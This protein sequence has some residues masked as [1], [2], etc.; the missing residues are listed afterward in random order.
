MVSDD[1]NGKQ[2]PYL[3]FKNISLATLIINGMNNFKP[4]LSIDIFR[5]SYKI[6]IWWIP[7]DPT[8]HKSL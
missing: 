8:D 2:Y 1:M 4:M 3:G 7:R 6:Y 5:I